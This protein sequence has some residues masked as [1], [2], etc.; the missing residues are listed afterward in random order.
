MKKAY[1]IPKTDVISV[2]TQQMLAGSLGYGDDVENTNGACS[3]K[4]NF[5]WEEDEDF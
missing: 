1:I 5:D 3:R 2:Q 4:N